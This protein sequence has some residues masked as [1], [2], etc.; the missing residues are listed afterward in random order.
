[1]KKSPLRFRYTTYMGEQHP[2]AS[3]I[4]VEFTTKELA[5]SAGLSEV[6]RSKLIKLLGVRYNPD[7]DLVRMSSEK[8]ENQ[9]QNKRYLGDLVNK[10]VAESRTGDMFEDIPFD[11]RHH[12][13]KPQHVF[14]ESWKLSNQQEVKRLAE[15]RQAVKSITDGEGEKVPVD[16]K[17]LMEAHVRA[18]AM[19]P[20]FARSF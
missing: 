6:Q 4:V 7:K 1:M 12:K 17:R 20:A 8:F 16:G 3:K 18:R 10:L 15:E 2:A 5:A 13:P 19:Q 11:F 14:P 9:A